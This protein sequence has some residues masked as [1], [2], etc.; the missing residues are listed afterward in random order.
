MVPKGQNHADSMAGLTMEDENLD[1]QMEGDSKFV[2]S[3]HYPVDQGLGTLQ[4]VDVAQISAVDQLG[5]ALVGSKKFEGS[6]DVGCLSGALGDLN[7][8]EILSDREQSSVQVDEDESL[9]ESSGT[10]KK[11]RSMITTVLSSTTW[12]P[13]VG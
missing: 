7:S 10:H 1:G 8:K 5:S 13:G 9:L 6:Q 4:V 12:P 3:Y 2:G 11:C